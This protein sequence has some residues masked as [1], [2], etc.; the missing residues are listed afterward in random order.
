MTIPATVR[1]NPL[2]KNLTDDQAAALF[3]LASERRV[4]GGDT[5]VRQFDRNTD[6][7][8][9]LE[10]TAAIRTFSGETVAEVG[11][12]A[13][14]GEVSLV[15]SEPRSANVVA[16]GQCKV[17]VIPSADLRGLLEHDHALKAQVMEN[18]GRIL[19]CRLRAANVHLDAASTRR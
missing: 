8:L 4:D 6:L 12:G 14:L 1:D 3:A 9:V 10:G 13:V 16:K 2:F 5:V 18:L 15:D 19:A 7:V 11:P 17:A